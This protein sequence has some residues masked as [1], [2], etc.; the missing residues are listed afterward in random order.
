LTH[1]G[2][3]GVGI[4]F[5]VEDGVKFQEHLGRGILSIFGSAKEAAA[6]LQDVAIVSGINAAQSFRVS[7]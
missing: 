2:T 1:P 5:F 6:H 4:V 3:E 7:L